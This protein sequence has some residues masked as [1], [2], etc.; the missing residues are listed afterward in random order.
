MTF[1]AFAALPAELKQRP[2]W[3][4]HKQKVP[5]NARTRK[6]ASST[7]PTT[8]STFEDA[9]VAYQSR[10]N[11]FS[12]LGY[13]FSVDDPYIGIDLDKCR[14]A[15]TGVTE[16]W[17]SSYIKLLNSYTELSPSGTGYHIF[18]RATT[19]LD[20][21]KKDAIEIYNKD[22]YFT[23]TGKHLDGTPLTI[24]ERDD[25]LQKLYTLVFPAQPARKTRPQSQTPH[26][27]PAEKESTMP[28]TGKSSAS[29]NSA[30]MSDAE[31]SII[32]QDSMAALMADTAD[33][34][35]RED[36][37]AMLLSHTAKSIIYQD[38]SPVLIP[39]D[40]VVRLISRTKQSEKFDALWRG[41]TSD[42]E[43]NASRADMALCSLLAFYCGP[44]G[45]VQVERLFRRSGLMRT[46][47]DEQRGNQTYGQRTIDNAYAHC[48]TFYQAYTQHD[49]TRK[50]TDSMSLHDIRYV[51]MCLD[52][53]EYGD[54]LLFA[55]L[56]KGRLVY[57][58]TEKAWY[59]WQGQYWKRDDN[60]LVKQLVSGHVARLYA[61]T[62]SEVL[63]GATGSGQENEE[64]AR[65][66]AQ[67]C[68][69]RAR[70]LHTLQRT[71]NVLQFATSSPHLSIANERWDTDPWLLGTPN[72]VVDLTSGSFR[73]GQPD[74]YIR[75]IVSAQWTGIESSCPRFERFLSEIFDDH[76]HKEALIGYLQRLLG[77]AITGLSRQAVLPILY[78]EEG[79]NGKSTLIRHLG[80]VLGPVAGTI[81]ND[82]LIDNRGRTPGSAQPYLA[83]LQGKR[84]VW[85]SE[86]SEGARF[87]IAQVKLITG[88]DA[89]NARRLYENDRT[90]LPTHTILLL[91]NHKPHANATDRAFWER[92]KLISF[93]LRF[94]ENPTQSHERPIDPDLDTTLAGEKSGIL[95]WLVRGCLE[96]QKRGMDTPASVQQATR[97][98]QKEEDP[99]EQFIE[100]EC[101][102]G[103]GYQIT[104][105]RFYD[106]Y[107]AWSKAMNLNPMSGGT[108]A[109][110]IGRRFVRN[111]M[112]RGY[113][114]IGVGVVDTNLSD[115]PSSPN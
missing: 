28:D 4:C 88:G 44:N 81:S 10:T 27:L 101:I 90:F 71:L 40:E 91:T 29:Q 113:I 114:Y 99:I 70:Q 67:L 111:R 46:K 1:N 34:I 102:E 48:E 24:E 95:A 39:D 20:R 30:L 6:M 52:C 89:I 7:D 85:T 5:Y 55:R 43:H 77:Y 16:E 13:V 96:Y 94:I 69:K 49:E 74:D 104:G 100:D 56:F 12:G 65:A 41:D 31:K 66:I 68:K 50:G 61:L 72:G 64:K 83:N 38:S 59:F 35:A 2:Q 107:C 25:E 84:L 54:S 60:G 109:K 19:T 8:W 73:K 21:H 47:W 53:S 93:N 57:D 17:A 87:N 63:K 26:P 105:K 51:C 18:V 9:Y 103:D 22:R 33:N 78:G 98:Y 42:Y 75:T 82:A 3:V 23:I 36:A 115:D 15:A 92:V 110:R 86:T 112:N 37:T 106:A 97:L 32:P 62:A 58:Y 45:Q 108:F 11:G 76:L 79:R 14:D 80:Q